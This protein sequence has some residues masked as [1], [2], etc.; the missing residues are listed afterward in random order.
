MFWTSIYHLEDLNVKIQ[1]R[2]SVIHGG[3]FGAC[4]LVQQSTAPGSRQEWPLKASHARQQFGILPAKID[5]ATR[6]FSAYYSSKYP[7]H[8]CIFVYLQP[9]FSVLETGDLI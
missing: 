1:R 5:C 7:D 3:E 2:N 6:T 8:C 9:Q 4:I